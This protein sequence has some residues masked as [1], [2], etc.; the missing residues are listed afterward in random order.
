MKYCLILT[1]LLLTGCTSDVL[2]VGK[3]TYMV[4]SSGAGFSTG[5]VRTS[6]IEKANK[7]C[8]EQGKVMVILSLD[9]QPGRLGRN[10]PSADLTF[11]AVAP[12]D[13]ENVRPNFERAPDHIQE[14]R[15]R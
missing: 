12:E 7:F 4:S 8:A 11:R 3:D 13:A 2:H 1:F 5:G 9:V 14:Y 15:V 6:V 10:P